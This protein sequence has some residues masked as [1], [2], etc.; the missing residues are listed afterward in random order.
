M[1]IL[2]PATGLHAQA[3]ELAACVTSKPTSWNETKK[4]A[5]MILEMESQEVSP[6]EARRSQ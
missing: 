6:E 3:I 4:Q 1:V 2:L 5:G